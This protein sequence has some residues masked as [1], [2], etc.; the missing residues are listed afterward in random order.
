MKRSAC[1][2]ARLIERVQRQNPT[3]LNED[4]VQFLNLNPMKNEFVECY[5]LAKAKKLHTVIQPTRA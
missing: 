2:T 1:R 5:D 3:N 4:W